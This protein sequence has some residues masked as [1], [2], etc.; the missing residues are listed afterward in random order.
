MGKGTFEVNVAELLGSNIPT[1]DNASDTGD[2]AAQLAILNSHLAKQAAFRKR[3]IRTILVI[4]IVMVLIPVLSAA[5]FTTST[6]T[7][8]VVTEDEVYEYED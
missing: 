6:S 8:S 7:Y 3:V 4:F 1:V 2:I 5:L